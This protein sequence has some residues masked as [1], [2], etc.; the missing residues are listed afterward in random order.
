MRRKEAPAIVVALII[1]FANGY[2]YDSY[3]N[4]F[5]LS[6]G[7]FSRDS[8]WGVAREERGANGGFILLI[9]LYKV[10]VH[11]L[12]FLAFHLCCLECDKQVFRM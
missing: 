6:W 9:G 10:C 11:V 7:F 5:F 3:F 2:F 8:I 12:T 4:V 1:Y